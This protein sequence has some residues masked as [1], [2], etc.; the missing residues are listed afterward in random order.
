MKKACIISVGNELISGDVVDTNSSWIAK[1]LLKFSVPVVSIFKIGDDVALISDTLKRAA[2]QADII[3]VTGGLGPTDDDITRNGITEFIGEDLHFDDL[4]WQKIESYFNR[5]GWVCSDKNKLQ[6]WFPDG[7]Q[8]IDNNLGTAPGFKVDFDGKIIFSMPGVPSEMKQMFAESV[9]PELEKFS[10]GTVIKVKKVKLFGKGESSIAEMLGD[11]MARG[12]NPLI[13]CTVSCGV[14]TLYI[15]A[16]AK[17][18][19]A[20]QQ[21]IDSDLKKLQDIF[22]DI[23]FGY[24]EQQFEHV[25]GELLR[26]NGKTLAIAESCTGGLISKMITDVPGASEYFT[27]GWVTYSNHAKISQLGVDD[28]TINKY[29]AVSAE[30]AGQMAIGAK[31]KSGSDYAIAVTGI[32]G[33]DGGTEQKPVG[34]VYIGIADGKNCDVREFKFSRDREFI[35][36][37]TA[38]MA[39]NLLRLK[40]SLNVV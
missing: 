6:A 26:R 37:R 17:N 36:L 2:E 27:F 24:D 32:A 12:R 35:R 39:L 29:G 18:E 3:F 28:E 16:T 19:Q 7:A 4:V 33:P 13:N 10:D 34:L 5:M 30:V 15:I 22:G 31:A 1:R 14:I 20:T 9:E 21:L 25:V 38:Q 11:L 8:I 40:V 23:I